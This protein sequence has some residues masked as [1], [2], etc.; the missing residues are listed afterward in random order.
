MSEPSP[1]IAI[2]W[3][4]QEILEILTAHLAAQYNAKPLSIEL[5]MEEAP[6]GSR[7]YHAWAEFE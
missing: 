1:R 3:L 2:V 6:D 5:Q 4:E 7:H